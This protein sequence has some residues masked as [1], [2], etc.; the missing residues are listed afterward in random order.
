MIIRNC[1][2]KARSTR[3]TVARLGEVERKINDNI[4]RNCGKKAKITHSDDERRRTNSVCSNREPRRHG[5]EE[6]KE[7]VT[8]ED[9]P[10]KRE[11]KFET[12]PTQGMRS[13]EWRSSATAG[14]VDRC[15]AWKRR[16]LSTSAG[17]K[18]ST[19]EIHRDGQKAWQR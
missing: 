19:I 12:L 4:V 8:L 3:V 18:R 17:R 6:K 5:C 7:K 10:Q 11:E 1:G 15:K 16:R 13:K 9:H 2:K 14:R